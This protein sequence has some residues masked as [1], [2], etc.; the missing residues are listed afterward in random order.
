MKAA[1]LT[2][3]LQ[4][5]ADEGSS[6]D[7][8]D[9]VYIRMEAHDHDHSTIIL[10]MPAFILQMLCELPLCMLHPPALFAT[11]FIMLLNLSFWHV[12]H[13]ETLIDVFR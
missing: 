2:T 5:Q 9:K 11:P 12:Q 4:Q 7:K 13:V 3:L 10:P 6:P 1:V 8:P